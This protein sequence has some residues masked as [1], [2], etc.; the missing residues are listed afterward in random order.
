MT[1]CPFLNEVG[2]GQQ[3]VGCLMSVRVSL[4]D[5]L[6]ALDCAVS[7]TTGMLACCVAEV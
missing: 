1:H 3:E 5:A 2:V 6:V 4:P 7:A